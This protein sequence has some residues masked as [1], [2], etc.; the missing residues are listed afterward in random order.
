MATARIAKASYGVMEGA[1]EISSTTK[2]SKRKLL[3][4]DE[5]AH[6]AQAK[7]DKL[8]RKALDNGKQK[9]PKKLRLSS[10]SAKA[11][12]NRYSG[13]LVRFVEPAPSFTDRGMATTLLRSEN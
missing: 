3:K 4:Q 13:A 6:E 8:Q 7:A 10:H 11:A 5:K 12:R 2:E 1:M 9:G